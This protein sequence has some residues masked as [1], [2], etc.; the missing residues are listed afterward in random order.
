MALAN[1]FNRLLL[2]TGNKSELAVGYCT[3][4]GDM[5]GALAVLADVFKTQA[6][7][8]ADWVNREGEI[9][10]RNT[11]VRPPTAEL[12]PGQLDQ[13]DLPPYAIL[14]RI[15][16]AYL[17]QARSI[18]AIANCVQVEPALVRDIARRV[19]LNEHKRV[20]APLGIRVSEKAFGMGRR[21]PVVQGFRE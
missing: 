18:E 13:D 15:L 12:K 11:I 19:R 1:K 20:Q 14:D 4:Y 16:R 9:I 8:L 7:A 10:P 21:F 2:S 6:Y 3:L 5:C 17:E